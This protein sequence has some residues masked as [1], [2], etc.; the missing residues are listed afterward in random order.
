MK[1]WGFCYWKDLS[2]NRV[3]F[4]GLKRSFIWRG[5][6]YLVICRS[7]RV[8]INDVNYLKIKKVVRKEL[9]GYVQ[10]NMNKYLSLIN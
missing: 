6:L 4:S 2:I 5:N 1:Q 7:F 3:V 8:T 9:R 10:V